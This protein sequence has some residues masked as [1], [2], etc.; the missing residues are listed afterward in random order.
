M[1]PDNKSTLLS[2]PR[3]AAKLDEAFVKEY[4]SPAFGARSKSEIDLLVFT[5]LIDA[6]AIDPDAP[7]DDTARAL[8]IPPARVRNLF[9]NWRLRS[10][11]PQGD[12]RGAVVR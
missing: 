5:C 12:L 1:A 11:P 8:N 3:I 4:M 7:V 2:K 9:L 6:K 10:T